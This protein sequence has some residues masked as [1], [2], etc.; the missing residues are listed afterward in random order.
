MTNYLFEPTE[1]QIKEVPIGQWATVISRTGSYLCIRG[2]DC[3][4]YLTEEPTN[5]N[6]GPFHANVEIFDLFKLNLEPRDG[7]EYGRYYFA[8]DRA[9]AEVEAWLRAWRQLEP[10]SQA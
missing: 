1:S 2:H 3:M 8:L 9:K 10:N 5:V 7:W 6:R 4:V